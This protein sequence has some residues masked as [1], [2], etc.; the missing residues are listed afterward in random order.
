MINK[1]LKEK[2]INLYKEGNTLP[3][4]CKTL[5]VSKATVSYQINKEGISRY[6]TPVTITEDLLSKMQDRYNECKNLSIVSKEFGVSINRLKLLNRRT[7]RT[8]YELLRN[9]R[10]RIKDLLVE[11]KGSKC[12]ICGYNKCLSALEFHHLDPNEKDFNISSNMKYANLEKLKKEVDKC[13]L[14]C[15]NCHR[16]IH[17]RI[18]DLDNIKN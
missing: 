3:Y 18:L 10:Y 9:R 13:I 2:I 8:N 15:A 14:V 7:P 6:K 1:E 5:E 12:Q 16:E 11:Y 17:A 4:I